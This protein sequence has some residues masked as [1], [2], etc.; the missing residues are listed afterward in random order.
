MKLQRSPEPG[1]CILTS[2]AMA[3]DMSAEN[4]LMRIGGRW[5]TFAF[6]NLPVPYC[7]RGIHIQE[8]ILIALEENFTV[9]PIEL[10]PQISSPRAID[11]VTR[12]TY[13][14][15]TV[16]HGDTEEKNWSIFNNTILTC[17][18][19]ITGRLAPTTIQFQRN[20]AVAFDKGTILDPSSNAFLYSVRECEARNF[21]ANTA[22]RFDRRV[23]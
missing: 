15:V 10:F 7:Y 16:F 22:W 18:G 17:F 4:L 23:Q 13:Q 8:L 1:L 19:V 3:L 5:K 20:H 2:F 11:P 14:N 6:P 12:R 21:Y 9:T